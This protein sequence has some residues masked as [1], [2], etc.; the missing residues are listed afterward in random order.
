MTTVLFLRR[1]PL[2]GYFAL[3]YGI[4]WGG[5]L[6]LLAGRGFELGALRPGDKGIVIAW[7]LLGP[8]A[9]GLAMTAWLDGRA[10]LRELGSRAVHWRVGWGWAAASLLTVPLLLLTLLW[11]LSVWLDPAFAP[12][13][14]PELFMLG[15][16]AGCCEEIG[17][18]GFATPRWLARR[19]LFA[20]GLQ[21]G[22]L[23]AVWHA[24]ADF[25]SNHA[26]MGA[27]WWA[28]FGVFWLATLPAYR[29]L[30][31]WV[32]VHTHSLLL[33]I[34]M[35]ASYTG[36]L[37]VLYPATTFEQGLVWQ[38]LFALGLWLAVA[39]MVRRQGRGRQ[40][41]PGPRLPAA[42]GAKRQALLISDRDTTDPL[43]DDLRVRIKGALEQQGCDVQAIELGAADV[44]PCTGCLACHMR[45][46]GVCVYR[47]ALTPINAKIGELDLVC[48]LG[49]MAF[50]QFG[51]TMKTAM[52]KLQTA[53]MRSRFTITIGHG[54]D[55]HDDEIATFVDIVKAHGGAANVVHPRFRARNEV[56]ATR[57][58]R[59]NE[60]V[61][62]ALRSSL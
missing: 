14:K 27:H 62:D 20:V 59:D 18:T 12:G 26:A 36:W 49:P 39:V 13:F 25:S 45:A 33:A 8:G 22:V 46:N 30:M 15:L 53:R 11:P 61:C 28:W 41:S 31:T 58:L 16:V 1:H 42:V 7:M 43:A 23:W 4:T 48:V 6:M 38:A 3:A 37:L 57:S 56:Y 55:A 2:V 51:S 44:V 34:L 35:H 5:I 32:Y 50:G 9:S 54:A 47:D 52:D 40:A 60:G 19:S 29:M 24:A 21:L 10:G 17:W